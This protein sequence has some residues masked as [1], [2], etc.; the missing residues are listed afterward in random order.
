M[1]EVLTAAMRLLT[2]REHGEHELLR[3]LTQK[4]YALSDAQRVVLEC[5]RLGL[6]SEQ[7]FAESIC[8]TRIQ[9]GYGP[10]YIAQ[11][12]QKLGIDQALVQDLLQREQMNWFDRAMAVW[13]KKYKKQAVDMTYA[14]VQKQKQ[15]LH[16]RGFTTETIN[17]VFNT[18]HES[19]R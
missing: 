19:C 1:N 17:A 4:G 3:K 8:R 11:A 7:R 5:Q 15:F 14:Q 18:I 10:L 2:R 16:Y 12:L 6:Q 9:Q 13:E